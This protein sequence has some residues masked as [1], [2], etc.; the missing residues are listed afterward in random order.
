LRDWQSV[1]SYTSSHPCLPPKVAVFSALLD[2][3]RLETSDSGT[4]PLKGTCDSY[5]VAETARPRCDGPAGRYLTAPYLQGL[6]TF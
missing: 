6:G 4:V 5:S 1:T 2:R 3:S